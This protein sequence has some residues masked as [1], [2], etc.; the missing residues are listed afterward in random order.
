METLIDNINDEDFKGKTL[1]TYTFVFKNMNKEQKD[2]VIAQFDDWSWGMGLHIAELKVSLDDE[3]TK[4][5]FKSP[6]TF[7]DKDDKDWNENDIENNILTKLIGK[8]Q[9]VPSF[10][11]SECG[12]EELKISFF[13]DKGKEYEVKV[14]KFSSLI[15]KK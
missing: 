3:Q 11:F 10:Q 14:D 4:F 12:V 15:Q 13:D 7:E 9:F 1:F 6:K 5:I 2:F 8:E